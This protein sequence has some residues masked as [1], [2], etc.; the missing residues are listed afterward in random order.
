LEVIEAVNTL[1]GKGPKDLYDCCMELSAN[2]LN[3]AM[4]WDL[5]HCY[6]M[7]KNA[8]N[9]GSAFKK[10]CEMVLAQGGDISVLE[11]LSKFEGAKIVFEVLSHCSGYISSMNTEEIGKASVMLGAGRVTKESTIDYTAGIILN[12]KT[13]D[14]VNEN[15][16]LATFY[17][18]DMSLIEG[19]KKCFVEA[20]SFSSI[21][22]AVKPIIYAKVER[23][24]VS[25]YN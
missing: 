24:N 6:K 8:I 13:G 18:S 7:A 15:E 16:T 9:S 20:L 22:P 17:A 12:K 23:D 14:F 5:D 19:A 10:L 3:L 21:K 2:L 4:D 1:K 11:D 25:Y